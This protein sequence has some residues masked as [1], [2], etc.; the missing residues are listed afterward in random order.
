MVIAYSH[1]VM[2]FRSQGLLALD[3][4][5]NA[6]P[7]GLSAMDGSPWWILL[8]D[9]LAAGVVGTAGSSFDEGAT[10]MFGSD[11]TIPSASPVKPLL[12]SQQYCTDSSF[13]SYSALL[14]QRLHRLRALLSWYSQSHNLIKLSLIS[15]KPLQDA[16]P[17]LGC[18]LP[19]RFLFSQPGAL[20]FPSTIPGVTAQP[21]GSLLPTSQTLIDT[22][23]SGLLSP[24]KADSSVGPP[25]ALIAPN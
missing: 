23:R 1:N 3:F 4:L 12:S 21:S 8:W 9:S 7:S 13:I 11:S 14:R 24:L 16:R 20:P 6:L 22:D 17:G 25:H 19:S 18:P 5:L 10:A 2:P 15:K